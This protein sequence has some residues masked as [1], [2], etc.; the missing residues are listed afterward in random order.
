M[1]MIR[2][3]L[4]VVLFLLAPPAQVL[5]GEVVQVRTPY[6]TYANAYVAGPE[7]A[8][9]AVLVIPDIWGVGAPVNGWVDRLGKM[10]LRAVV[11]DLYDGRMVTS[12]AMAGEVYGTIDPDWIRQDL[13]G[14]MAYLNQR[15]GNIVLMGWGEGARHA[16]RLVQSDA[17]GVN[18]VSAVAVY[19]DDRAS[20]VD[21]I[22]DLGLP[23]LDV[24]TP[25][26]LVDPFRPAKS[27]DLESTWKATEGFLSKR[28]N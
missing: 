26:S 7:A 9:A 8:S 23:V 2:R 17:P 10:G 11:V 14:A 25:H 6:S 5:A 21:L 22:R 16:V 24:S 13:K 27:G 19:N 28:L 20:A 12:A 3:M 4:A 15:Y 1:N 18:K